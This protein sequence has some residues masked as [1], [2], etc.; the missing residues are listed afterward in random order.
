MKIVKMFNLMSREEISERISYDIR[1][2][3][4]CCVYFPVANLTRKI[5]EDI[6]IAL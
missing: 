1:I 2:D 4:T 6:R 5:M 3:V